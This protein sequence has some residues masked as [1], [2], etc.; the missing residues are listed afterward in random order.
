MTFAQWCQ[1]HP[2]TEPDDSCDGY[3]G[4][5]AD[6]GDVYYPDDEED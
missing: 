4:D 1:Q 2:D 6:D 3:V 5:E